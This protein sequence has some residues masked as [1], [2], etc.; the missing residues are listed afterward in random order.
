L[1]VAGHAYSVLVVRTGTVPG[2]R[3]AADL[4]AR[5][6]IRDAAVECF[7][8]EGFDAPFR[9]IARRAAV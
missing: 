3:P 1:P 6:R 2:D 7:A 4:T 9:A 8:Q 5:A